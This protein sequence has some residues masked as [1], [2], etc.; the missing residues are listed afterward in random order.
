MTN[1]P[2]GQAFDFGKIRPAVVKKLEEYFGS[3]EEAYNV[4]LKG[5]G[6]AIAS[7]SNIGIKTAINLLLQD[8]QHREGV[9]LNTVLKTKDVTAM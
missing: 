6:A 4:I 3:Q 5:Q 2:G 7:I 8:L 9:N 1:T